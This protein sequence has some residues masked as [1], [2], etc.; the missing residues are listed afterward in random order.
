MALDRALLGLAAREGV[1]VFRLYGWDPACLSF[2][3]HE[4]AARRY[5]RAQI[6]ARGID[7]VRRPTG[8]RAVWHARELTYAFA[9]PEILLGGPRAT[10]Q[11]IHEWLA[12]AVRHL[13]L[14][15]TLAPAPARVPRPADGACFAAPV[16]G[17][18]MVL[19][20][21]VVGSAQV[22]DRGAVLQHGSM[23][24]EDDQDMVRQLALTPD[25]RPPAERPLSR[26][27]G[28]TLAWSEAADATIVALHQSW[29]A[30]VDE[31]AGAARF[32]PLAEEWAPRFQDP[33]WTWE[34]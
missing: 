8:G 27:A 14:P 31:P 25:P 11:Q 5:D 34:R 18:V 26:L 3:R 15:A 13:D 21:K 19:G 2:G 23:L 29:S 22:R 24:L 20:W 12:R 33:Q 17:E 7:C 30:V 28:R 6:T 4:P 1:A 32:L 16:G 10:Y 9:A